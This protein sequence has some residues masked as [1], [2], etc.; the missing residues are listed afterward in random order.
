MANSFAEKAVRF[1]D[2]LDEVY[3]REALTAILDVAPEVLQFD[4]TKTVK[5]PKVL[6]DGAADYSRDTGYNK[7]SVSVSYSVHE[8]KYDRGR[9]FGVDILDD[10]EAAFNVFATV[11]TEFVRTRQIPEIDAIR[12]AEIYDKANDGEGTVVTA[13]LTSET[14]LAALDTA[15]LVLAD[16]EVNMT[17]S[18]LFISNEMYKLLK[19]DSTVERR[20][21]VGNVTAGGINRTVT[22]FDGIPLIRVPKSRFMDII[23]LNDGTT[24]GQTAGGFTHVVDSSRY[25]NF[26]FADKSALLGIKKAQ[27]SKV[28][29]WEENQFSDENIATYRD[30][31]DLVIPENKTKGIYIH[32]KNTFVEAS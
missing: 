21:D 27:I 19:E 3:K 24:A 29:G 15:E 18:V 13:D 23:Q 4:G 9:K 16:A 6:V 28:F 5:L 31:H 10:D 32:R 1:V 22:T 30:H 26:I 14:A 7:G 17:N 2:V 20:L 8:I 11:T 12:F 25:M